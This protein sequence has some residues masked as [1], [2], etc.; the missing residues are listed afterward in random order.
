M[1][2]LFGI[3]ILGLAATLAKQQVF[4]HPP[5]T[6]TYSIFTGAFAVIAAAVGT[7]AMF[8]EAIPSVVPMG[9]DAVG[10]LLLLAGGIVSLTP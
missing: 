6:T 9:F 8:M 4:G 2:V 3:V 5:T 10:G 1:Q 7:I